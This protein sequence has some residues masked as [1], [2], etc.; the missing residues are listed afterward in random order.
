M[1]QAGSGPLQPDQVWQRMVSTGLFDG[2]AAVALLAIAVI[3][4]P[5]CL[6][7]FGN[8]HCNTI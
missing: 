3:G 6:I 8:G 4:A 1:V 5:S 2:L 7:D